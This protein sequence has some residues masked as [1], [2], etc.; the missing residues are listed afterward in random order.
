LKLRAHEEET[1]AEVRNKLEAMA[2]AEP[3]EAHRKE[4][5]LRLFDAINGAENETMVARRAS[6]R[7]VRD[8]T[9]EVER[10]SATETAALPDLE[11]SSA[12]DALAHVD[13][14]D[15]AKEAHVFMLLVTLDRMQVAEQLPMHLKPYVVADAMHVVFGTAAP[16]LPHD[17][18]KPLP[19]GGWLTYLSN[20]AASAGH[21]VNDV[22]LT[23]LA[24]H[25][26][27]VAGILQGIADQLKTDAPGVSSDT[28]LARVVYDTIRALEQS[29][30][31]ASL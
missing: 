26:Q 30:L 23:P 2:Q 3:A 16:D 10:F 12:F 19:P 27:A 21:P 18:S 31:R 6:H 4:A 22:G 25:E 20:A 7:L 14:G 15:L 24:R 1:I 13:A 28:A 5:Y 17:A 8:S 9:R 29:K 11:A